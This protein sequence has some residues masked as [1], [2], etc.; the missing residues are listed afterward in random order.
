VEI[1]ED[2][3]KFFTSDIVPQ[4]VLSHHRT[5][6]CCYC[7]II[8]HYARNHWIVTHGIPN[9]KKPLISSKQVVLQL[10]KFSMQLASSLQYQARMLLSGHAVDVPGSAV[11]ELVFLST[12]ALTDDV[13]QSV[14]FTARSIFT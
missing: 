3:S 9:A 1:F 12:S 4:L 6:G 2:W 13:L 7:I 11:P 14:I 5:D 8:R 10:W